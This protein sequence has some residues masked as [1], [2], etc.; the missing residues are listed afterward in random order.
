M[1]NYNLTNVTAA[2]NIA[3]QFVA[4]NAMVD[5]LL[6]VMILLMLFFVSYTIMRSSYYHKKFTI[7]SFITSIIAIL[8]FVVGW[9]GVMYVTLFC[10]FFLICLILEAYG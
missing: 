2:N 5:G 4:V 6:S 3:Q 9:I 10:V 7:S 1:T 8:M